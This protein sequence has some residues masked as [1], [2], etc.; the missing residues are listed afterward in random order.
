MVIYTKKIKKKIKFREQFSHF[1]HLNSK[2]RHNSSLKIA[3]AIGKY[4][5]LRIKTVI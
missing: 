4:C 5:F 1:A 3:A 2:K